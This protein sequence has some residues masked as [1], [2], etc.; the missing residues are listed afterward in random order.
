MG[1]LL[2][3]LEI[4]VPIE[5]VDKL[6]NLY[7]AAPISSYSYVRQLI[8]NELG[9][10]LEEIFIEF[11]ATPVKSGSIAQIH[12]AKLKANGEKVAVKIQHSKLKEELFTDMKLIEFFVNVGE[13]MFT[14]FNYQWLIQDMKRNLPQEV[15]FLIEAS[16]CEKMKGLL[17]NE[18]RITVPDIYNQATTSKILTMSYEEGFAITEK[19]RMKKENI[20]VNSVARELAYCFSRSIFEYG[21]VHADPHPGNIFVRK[22][23]KKGFELI[24]LDH[25]IYRPLSRDIRVAYSTL[26]NG[27]FLQDAGIIKNACKLIGLEKEDYKIFTA[28]VT[29]QE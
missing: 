11:D 13:M 21:F 25:S 27:I 6:S 20:D 17:K 3:S 12:F 10:D 5:I 15:D 1:Q 29:K 22:D 18:K 14:N 16:N 19:E 8:K 7:E 4:L 9:R 2:A 28:M 24:L 26:W 23:K